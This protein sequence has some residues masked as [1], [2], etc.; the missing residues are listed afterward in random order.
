MYEMSDC[1]CVLCHHH[2]SGSSKHRCGGGVDHVMGSGDAI[3]LKGGG[4]TGYLTEDRSQSRCGKDCQLNEGGGC[5]GGCNNIP[6][7]V[8]GG[9]LALLHGGDT[10]IPAWK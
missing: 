9:L 6:G 5:G 3:G 10:L 4:R 2:T 8:E 1:D 7:D